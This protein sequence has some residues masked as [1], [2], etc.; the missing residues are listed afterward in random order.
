MNLPK[1]PVKSSRFGEIPVDILSPHED[2]VVGCNNMISLLGR[3]AT[4]CIYDEDIHLIAV[5]CE[6]LYD[7]PFFVSRANVL[8]RQIEGDRLM[9]L[10]AT[11]LNPENLPYEFDNDH[12]AFVIYDAWDYNE[13]KNMPEVVEKVE[14][15]FRIFPDAEI[16]KFLILEGSRLAPRVEATVLGR[17]EYWRIAD[18]K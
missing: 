6:R 3:H 15:L 16:D 11:I 8:P 10:S 1:S 12:R 14:S 7:L 18:E 4:I 9:V 13:C 2:V 17:I 5:A